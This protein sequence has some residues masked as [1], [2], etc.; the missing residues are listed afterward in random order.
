MECKPTICIHSF[1]VWLQISYHYRNHI[2]LEMPT[3]IFVQFLNEVS[4]FLQWQWNYNRP[5]FVSQL[6]PPTKSLLSKKSKMYNY[7]ISSIA[8]LDVYSS[9]STAHSILILEL[10]YCSMHKIVLSTQMNS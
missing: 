6:R 5:S 8:Y 10:N 2:S 4:L 9:T 7:I 3:Q 1:I